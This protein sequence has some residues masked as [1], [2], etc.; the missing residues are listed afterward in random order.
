MV[1]HNE[2]SCA[3]KEKNVVHFFLFLFDWFQ[4]NKNQLNGIA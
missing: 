4:E 3:T 1:K 2:N